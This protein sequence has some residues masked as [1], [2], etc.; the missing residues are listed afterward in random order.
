V[1]LPLAG[2]W[3]SSAVG[4]SVVVHMPDG[5]NNRMACANVVED[6]DV[7]KYATIRKAR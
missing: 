3:W 7:V 1:N 6:K 4:K 5:D 2:D